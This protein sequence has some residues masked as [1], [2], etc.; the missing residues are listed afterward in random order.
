MP[1]LQF[2]TGIAPLFQCIV[3]L[4]LIWPAAFA[5]SAVTDTLW[6]LDVR[7]LEAGGVRAQAIVHLAAPPSTVQTVLTDYAKW[8]E[9]FDSTLRVARIDHQRDRV[10]TDLYF[11]HGL[12][13]G[14]HHLYCE[15]KELPGGGLVTRM[16][17]GDFRDYVRTWTVRPSQSGSGTRAEL[18]LYLVADT[19][20]PDWL[21]ALV[22]ESELRTHFGLLKKKVEGGASSQ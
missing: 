20:A 2:S 3:G 17:E 19:W 16:L 9:L 1:W 8:P 12:L 13:M 10:L 11:E 4:G 6:S 14:E 7:T 5:A 22:L 15:N 21:L 18:D